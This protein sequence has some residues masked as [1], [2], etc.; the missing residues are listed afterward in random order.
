MST[1]VFDTETTGLVKFDR[2]LSDPSQPRLVQIGAVLYDAKREEAAAMCF[3]VR[4]DGWV[5]EDG[6]R[7]VH[8]IA[9]RRAELYGIRLKAALSV[10]IDLVRSAAEIVAYNEEFDSRVIDIELMR[11]KALPPEWRRAGLRRS[12]AMAEAAQVANSGI[13]MKLPAAHL[14]LTGEEYVPTHNGLDDAR[15][16]ARVWWAVCDRR[17][18][19]A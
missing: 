14:A 10:F 16:A 15:A 12:C 4:P 6:A 11:I 19:A 17:E 2:P 13:S 5:S 3:L 1:L 9:P 18:V 7:K 8:S